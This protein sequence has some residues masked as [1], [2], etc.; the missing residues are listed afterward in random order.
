MQLSLASS[1]LG[2]MLLLFSGSLIPPLVVAWFYGD[3]EFV[4]FSVILLISLLTGLLFWL[5]FRRQQYNLHTRDGFI[6]VNL[7]WIVM[8]ML[9]ALPFMFGLQMNLA[10]AVFEAV[11]GFTTTGATVIIGLDEL[12]HSILFFRQEI[13]WFGGIGFVVSA[14]A[15]LP[16]LGVGG[17]QLF[18][19]ETPG[20]MKDEKLTPRITSTA[21]ILWRIYALLT[22]A[23]ALA[24][25]LAGMSP[26]DAIAHALTTLSTGGFSTH[27]ASLGWFRSQTIE[28]IAMLFMLLG[29][30][31]FAL[32]FV[33]WHGRSLKGYWRS[34]E[35]R[36]FLLVVAVTVVLCTLVNLREGH[37]DSLWESL[38]I[39]GFTVVSVITSTGFGIEDFSLWP[40][41]LPLVLILISF[42]GACSGSTSGGMKSVRFVILARQSVLV[43][44][45]LVHPAMVRPLK[46]DGRVVAPRVVDAV[47]GFF[48]VYVVVFVLFMLGLMFDG[49]DQLSAFGAVATCLNNLGPGLGTVSTNFVGVDDSVKW[50]LSLAM[51]LGRLEIFTVLVLFAPAFWRS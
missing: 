48:A 31:S 47:W 21:R 41:L 9:Y 46:L 20:P 15:I 3:G 36:V 19:A 51:L 14:V 35:V 40:T 32:H 42:M 28:T 27:D 4:H 22:L 25:W 38:R 50:I 16:M 29:G 43:I 30:I 11:S 7:F 8:G 37:F 33:A 1:V 2:L 12:P 49:M 23:C 18:K 26:F 39:S 13:Q 5:P 10:D 44:Q 45:R 17:M 6:I 34:S 24:Y